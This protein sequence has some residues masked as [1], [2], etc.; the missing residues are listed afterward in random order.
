MSSQL[1]EN[2]YE[3]KYAQ[4]LGFLS[5][6]W[7]TAENELY[8][9][10]LH[11]SQVSDAVGRAIFSGIRASVMMDYI[12]SIAHNTQMEKVRL[13]D[14]E[15]V[16]EQMAAINKM[17]DR[18][19]H[20]SMYSYSYPSSNPKQRLLTNETRASRYG[21]AFQYLVEPE[22]IENMIFDLHGISNHLNMH[23]GPRTGDFL[24]WEENPGE[25]TRWTYPPPQLVGG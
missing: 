2:D 25:K 1:P 3:D 24:A 6:A 13:E 21:K 20:F 15:F 12:K 4:A 11:Y 14:L 7:A 23:W 22:T 18:L 10:L 16:F 8:R 9:V 5:I 17:R 19:I